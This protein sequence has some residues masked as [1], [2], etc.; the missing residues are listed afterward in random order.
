[1]ADVLPRLARPVGRDAVTAA[2]L[3]LFLLGF[4]CRL[5]LI[6]RLD[7]RAFLFLHRPLS[8]PPW[9]AA[10]RAL[11]HLGRTPAAVLALLLLAPFV[12]GD[13]RGWGLLGLALGLAALAERLVKRTMKR[14]RPFA[15]L[16]GVSM[17]QPRQPRDPSFPSGDALRVWFLAAAYA[18]YLPAGAPLWYALAL[19]VSLG[20]VAL[21]V[22]HPL[23][24]LSGASLGALSALL[25]L[26]L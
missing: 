21:G 4:A 2:L 14:P 8:R 13:Y 7:A 5:P 6:A 19:L 26:R 11:W 15:A 16:P 3:I 23:D 17:Q 9:I 24:V 10:F 12:G 22:H 20:R 25:A 18:H 1:M